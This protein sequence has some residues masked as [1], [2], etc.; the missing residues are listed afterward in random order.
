MIAHLTDLAEAGSGDAA[1]ALG[2]IYTEGA[3]VVR[4]PSRGVYWFLKGA[5]S[6]LCEAFHNLGVAFEFGEGTPRDD[7]QA[8]EW[9][10]KGAE[11]GYIYSQYNLAGLYAQKRVV[12]DVPEVGMF[13]IL[14]AQQEARKVAYPNALDRYVLID[15]P[16]FLKRLRSRLPHDKIQLTEKEAERWTS[17][18]KC[19]E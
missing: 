3:Q 2:K 7:Q 8:A 6:G 12:P 11:G 1:I 17:G 9:Y 13:W 18:K 4:D 5:E 10:K 14:V 16:R 15:P 19:P